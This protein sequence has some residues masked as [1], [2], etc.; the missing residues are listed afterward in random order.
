MSRRSD[1]YLR[2]RDIDWFFKANGCFYH[3]ASNGGLL[4]DEYREISLINNIK[5]AV[6]NH[7]PQF[8]PEELQYNDDYID[9]VV[10][11]QIEIWQ[12]LNED[13]NTP[14]LDNYI[15]TMFLSS[16]I[17]MAQRGFV[18]LDRVISHNNT[19]SEDDDNFD[20][21]VMITHPGEPIDNLRFYLREE[22]EIEIPDFSDK[23]T[24]LDNNRL[25]IRIKE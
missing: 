3:C 24:L 1:D 7:V 23:V 16:F 11:G 12:R 4:P 25:R 21:Y 5:E 15:R 9:D 14:E 13:V 18:S 22:E 6:M 17:F 19:E 20:D 10:S 8:Y 2:G